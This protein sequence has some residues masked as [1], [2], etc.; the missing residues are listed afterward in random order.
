M[1]MKGI[2][3]GA[4]CSPEVVNDCIKHLNTKNIVV[5]Y[6]CTETSP[7]INFNLFFLL[8]L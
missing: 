1:K 7:C 2:M 6:G 3:S 8:N 5:V 4:T